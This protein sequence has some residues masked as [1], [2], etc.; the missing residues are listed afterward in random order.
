MGPQA[1]W[2]AP[3]TNASDRA[4]ERSAAPAI[5]TAAARLQDPLNRVLAG[6]DPP[7]A[8]QGG[9]DRVG[10]LF[11]SPPWHRLPWHRDV[12]GIRRTAIAVVTHWRGRRTATGQARTHAVATGS[13][14]L[15]DDLGDRIKDPAFIPECRDGLKIAA[16]S[17]GIGG[18]A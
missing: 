16:D 11:L 10:V 13:G 15:V 6:D 12:S 7:A 1:Y 2:Q 4:A 17:K 14:D 3:R 5:T 8:V 9:D 18:H